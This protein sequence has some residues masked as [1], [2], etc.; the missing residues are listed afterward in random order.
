MA[1][2]S[3]KQ[4]SAD[5][6]I[7][8]AFWQLLE[9]HDYKGITVGMITE[10]AE[11]NRGSF[12][13]HYPN[14]EALIDSVIN[15]ELHGNFTFIQVLFSLAAGVKPSE[16]QQKFAT[17]H[18]RRF[19]L[20]AERGGLDLIDPKIKKG[21][22]RMWKTILC[23]NGEEFKPNTQA[24]AEYVSSGIMG[25]LLSYHRKGKAPEDVYTLLSD[26][27][28]LDISKF[29]ISHIALYQDIS[30]KEIIMRL[31]TINH[32]LISNKRL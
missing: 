8:A 18:I 10:K 25:L 1:R 6:R 30:E 22:T 28:I 17:E 3:K 23:P 20:I 4:E 19:W 21:F 32:F 5:C 14:I 9:T 31:Q 24:L 26:S 2:P 29:T 15:E 11:C 12:Y 13:Y 16:S 7:K 27:L